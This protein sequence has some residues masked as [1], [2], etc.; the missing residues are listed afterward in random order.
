MGTQAVD[1]GRLVGEL[2]AELDARLGAVDAALARH[3]PGERPGR[4]PVHTVYV[5]AD[6]F[7]AGL[8]PAYGAAALDATEEHEAVLLDL[9]EHD[10]NL[11]ARVR[12]YFARIRAATEPVPA[13]IAKHMGRVGAPEVVAVKSEGPPAKA[14]AAATPPVEAAAGQDQA[15]VIEASAE[16]ADTA[17]DAKAKKAK[18]KNKGKNKKKAK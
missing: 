14:D 10:E 8:V 12:D 3:Y 17:A 4:Q 9:L 11:L 16:V 6:R 1:V 15:Q 18:A 2:A 13:S 7:H 5:P